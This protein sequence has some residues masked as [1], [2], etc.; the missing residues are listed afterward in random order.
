MWKILLLQL[1][2]LTKKRKQMKKL[3]FATLFAVASLGAAAQDNTSNLRFSVGLDGALPMGD[4]KDSYSF[5]IGGSAQV[6]YWLDPSL[7]ITGQAGYMSYSGK[8]TTV[9]GV[10]YKPKALGAIPVLAGIEYNFTPQVFASAQLGM[11]F[12]SGSGDGSAF[13]YAP[14]IGFRLGD[15]VSALV[16]YQAWSKNS[17]TNGQI[18]LRLAYSF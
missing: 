17:A 13:T 1:N 6:N 8:E 18:G 3:I 5:G 11:S 2:L 4:W 15:N 9:A 7:A 10:T 14:G 16:K 12:F